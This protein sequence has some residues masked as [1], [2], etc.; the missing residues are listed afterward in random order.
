MT[1]DEHFEFIDRIV[2]DTKHAL[3]EQRD[4]FGGGG[5]SLPATDSLQSSIF[6]LEYEVRQLRSMVR[7]L[8]EAAML[9]HER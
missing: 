4:I 6:L 7:D 5:L 1:I 8:Q 3:V 2:A 9:E